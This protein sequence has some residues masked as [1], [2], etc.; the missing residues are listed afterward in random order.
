MGQDLG[1]NLQLPSNLQVLG[2]FFDFYYAEIGPPPAGTVG[3]PWPL[4]VGLGPGCVALHSDSSYGGD[5]EDGR[6]TYSGVPGDLFMLTVDPGEAVF[7]STDAPLLFL[8]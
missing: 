4:G 1:T 5:E 3:W 6:I 7:M 8:S 2:I